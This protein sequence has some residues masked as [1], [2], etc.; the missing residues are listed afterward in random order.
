LLL[1]SKKFVNETQPLLTELETKFDEANKAYNYCVEGYG[2]E[3]SKKEP[4]EFFK[5]FED[6]VGKIIEVVSKIDAA[7]EKEEKARQREQA[8]LTSPQTRGA[9]AGAN[10]T[11][12]TTSTPTTRGGSQTRGGSEPPSTSTRGGGASSGGGGGGRGQSGRGRGRGGD[13]DKL[14]ENMFN[15]LEGGNIF[16]QNRRGGGK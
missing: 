10:T 11:A 16:K 4:G 15:Q 7:R 3:P 12:A 8:K 2:E 5:V 9:K 13:D 1:L 14:V 6:F